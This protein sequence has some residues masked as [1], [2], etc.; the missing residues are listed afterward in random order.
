MKNELK[1]HG[2]KRQ[3]KF[4]SNG[5]DLEKFYPKPVKKNGK[6]I[7]HV[8]R[9][10]YEK[11]I[12]VL[13]KAFKLVLKKHPNAKLLIV[14]KGPDMNRLKKE[15]GSYLNKNIKFLGPVV[16]EKL[17]KV[18][19][20]VDIFATA[21]TIE[22][23]GLVILEA[24]A[25]G[26]P[27]VGVNALAIPTIVKHGRNGFIAESKDLKEIANYISVLLEKEELRNRFGKESLKIVKNF[28]LDSI[29]EQLESIYYSL[30]RR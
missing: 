3:I 23:E 17:I 2:I 22:T 29:I 13:I 1:K 8:G 9:I 12:D 4:L 28:S 30:I 16:H 26:L 25:C 27:I 18:Y 24:M 20:G 14:G 5:V 15:A 7:L 19:S 11:N 6:T 10:S 21:S